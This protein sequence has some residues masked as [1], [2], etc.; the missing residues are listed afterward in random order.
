METWR[1]LIVDNH[2][3]SR[4]GFKVVLDTLEGFEVVGEAA[5]GQ[6]AVRLC[7]TLQPN[8]ILMDVNMPNGNGI[9]ATSIIH[10]QY[11]SIIIIGISGF[12]HVEIQNEIMIAGAAGYISKETD[13]VEMISLIRQIIQGASTASCIAKNTFQLTATEYK[14][15]T[16]L[17]K[18]YDRQLV[19]NYL[20]ISINT[21]KM[22]FRNLYQKLGVANAQDAIKTALTYHLIS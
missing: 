3:I 8:L 22:H 14:I 16:L 4:S 1:T 19:A 11:P 12:N 18:G 2:P 5:T 21:V 6:E 7:Q 15:L 13:F 17:V 20:D 9:Q 10:R